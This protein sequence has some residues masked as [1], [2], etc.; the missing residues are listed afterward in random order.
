[1]CFGLRP[2]NLF[3][4]IFFCC[5]VFVCLLIGSVLWPQ[6]SKVLNLRAGPAASSFPQCPCSSRSSVIVRAAAYASDS[7]ESL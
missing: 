3:L 2:F 6:L 5:F 4:P 1:M 7:G